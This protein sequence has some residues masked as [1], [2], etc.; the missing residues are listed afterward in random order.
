MHNLKNKLVAA[1]LVSAPEAKVAGL[2]LTQLTALRDEAVVA[3]L[4][5]Q[6]K[7]YKHSPSGDFRPIAEEREELAAINKAI[8]KARK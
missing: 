8:R 4:A 1:G 5:A 6:G 7:T 2:T 3:S